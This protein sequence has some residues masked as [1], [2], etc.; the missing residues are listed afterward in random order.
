RGRRR[1]PGRNREGGAD[2][3]RDPGTTGKRGR[4]PVRGLP[5]LRGRDLPHPRRPGSLHSGV[6]PRP[7]H[8]PMTVPPEHTQG[9]T[10]QF[11][12]PGRRRSAPWRQAPGRPH[13][14]GR[15]RSFEPSRGRRSPTVERTRFLSGSPPSRSDPTEERPDLLARGERAHPSW[16]RRPRVRDAGLQRPRANRSGAP[17]REAT[18]KRPGPTTAATV[19]KV[20]GARP[21]QESDQLAAEEPMEIRVESGPKGQRETISLSVTMRTP[22]HDFELAAGFLFTEGIVARKGDI[23]RIEYWT[24]HGVAQEYNI[25]ITVFPPDVEFLAGRTPLTGTVLAVSGR[26]SFEILQKAAV[27]GIPF[28]IAIGA[29]SSLAVAIAEEFGMTLVGFARGDRFN[30]YAGAERIVNLAR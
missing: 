24:D 8:P 23:A 6:A 22:G 13:R 4:I 3:R 14:P 27:A 21:S 5:P 29:P 16:D 19:W 20:R 18:M 30:I 17:L 11:D 10:I 26:S 2:L 15:R 12:D 25:V 1:D 7:R 28:V 9:K